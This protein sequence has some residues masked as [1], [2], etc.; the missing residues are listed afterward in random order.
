MFRTLD[1][2]P[3]HYLL[4]AV[5][6]ALSCLPNLGGPTLWDIDEGLNAEAA[7]EMLA[8]GNLVVPTFNYQL[9]SA[10]PVLLY[11]LQVASY[12]M[13]G[14]NEAAA[15]FPSALAVLLAVL[16]TYELGRALFGL[17]TGLL[18][19]VLLA[20]SV[21]VLGAAHF[22]NPDALLL[23]FTTVTLA[24][25]L[26]YAETGS[27][28]WIYLAGLAAGLAV[29][30]KGPVGLLLP[31]AIVFLYLVWQRQLGRLLA[32]PV[33]EAFLLFILVAAPWYV[34][35]GVET[36][37]QFLRE[38]WFI[39]HLNRV[40]TPMEN[41]HGSPLY[42]VVVLL[43]GLFPA[44]LFMGASVW[45][46]G[47]RLWQAGPDRAAVRF[48]FLWFAIF[49][50]A[51]SIAS[52]KLPNYIL[53]LYPAAVLLSA[54]TLERWRLGEFVLPRW[55]VGVSV[56]CLGLVGVGVIVAT[57]HLGGRIDLGIPQGWQV[58]AL[59]FWWW[60][61]LMPL[62]GALA[63]AWLLVRGSRESFL[64]SLLA[65]STAFVSFVTGGAFAPL[66]VV[67]PQAPLVAM[68]P[69][70]QEYREVRL[71]AFRYD[72]PT[73]VFYCRR[74]VRRLEV[75]DQA[76][77]FL[78]EPLPTYLFVEEAKWKEIESQMPK[79]VRVLAS[80]PDFYKNGRPVL[81]VANEPGHVT[82]LA[83]R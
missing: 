11:W 71:G 32:L 19:G 24:A 21:S 7:R 61:G 26:R 65:A 70:D 43:V 46:T 23:A 47:Q 79:G 55:L 29:L 54:W 62:A 60:L 10:K 31:G 76:R 73:L 12:Q 37:G 72:R 66:N 39:H 51:F 64:V 69:A 63:C 34:W 44:S 48:L 25:F 83:A 59:A 81:L 41:H 18:A 40:K 27:R 20:T 15:R 57:L 33:G 78:A 14:V 16:A 9:R 28:W 80:H 74:E 22:A 67:K 36:K 4:L 38:F 42:Y 45:H 49:F 13:F 35:V 50:A 75:P 17:R 77:Q 3:G 5:I 52:T 1:C 30:A 6:W 56:A 2:R 8:S 68:L 82:W 53:P 58:P